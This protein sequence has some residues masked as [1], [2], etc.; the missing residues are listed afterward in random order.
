MPEYQ[1]Q[2]YICEEE[3]V[4]FSTQIRVATPTWPA[5]VTVYPR[6][7]YPVDSRTLPEGVAYADAPTVSLSSTFLRQAISRDMPVR[8]M[9]PDGVEQYILQ[10]RL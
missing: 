8:H 7:G 4:S 10:E 3:C 2:R 9:V 6:P 1:K 5:G